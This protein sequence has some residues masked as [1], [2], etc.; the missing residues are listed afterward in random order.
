MRACVRACL[1]VCRRRHVCLFVHVRF[2]VYL[3][4]CMGALPFAN[5]SID[6]LRSQGR[7]VLNF[8]YASVSQVSRWDLALP[9]V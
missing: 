3:V 1:C 8:E 5:M 9:V 7:V 2:Y 6:L 4:M